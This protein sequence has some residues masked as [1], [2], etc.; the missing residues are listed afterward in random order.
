[1]VAIWCFSC[2]ARHTSTFWPCRQNNWKAP[3]C[4]GAV[5]S[6]PGNR[7]DLVTVIG[8]VAPDLAGILLAGATARKAGSGILHLAVDTSAPAIDAGPA[9]L[10]APAGCLVFMG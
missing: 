10:A 7:R 2:F 4:A 6:E 8:M 1:M 9:T 3:A 5:E